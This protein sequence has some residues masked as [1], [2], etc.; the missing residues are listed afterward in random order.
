MEKEQIIDQMINEVEKTCKENG[1][2]VL[3]LVGKD[4][5]DKIDCRQL[6]RISDGMMA[7]M[8][9]DLMKDNPHIAGIIRMINGRYLSQKLKDSLDRCMEEVFQSLRNTENHTPRG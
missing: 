8:I 6:L 3:M 5:G 1:L 4:M 7:D 2:E 9:Y